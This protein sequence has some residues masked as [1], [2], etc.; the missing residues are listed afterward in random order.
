MAQL[1]VRKLPDD[2]VAAHDRG[3]RNQPSSHGAAVHYTI[4]WQ[5]YSTMPASEK[6][7]PKATRFCL[8]TDA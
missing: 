2:L 3:E 8:R 6:A 1:L 5:D 7:E 4:P